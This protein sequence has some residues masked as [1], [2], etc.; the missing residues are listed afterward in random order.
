VLAAGLVLLA[1]CLSAPIEA[2]GL[3]YPAPPPLPP[4]TVPLP[5]VS[6]EALIWQP[7]YWDWTGGGYIWREG[8]WDRRG[9]HSTEWMP[10]YWALEGG[11]WRWVPGH[12]I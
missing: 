3:P 1:G 9:E 5:P 11:I 12:W 4:E 7:G 6:E 8:H 2:T 10:G